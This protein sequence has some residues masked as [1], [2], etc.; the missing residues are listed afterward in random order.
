M[1]VSPVWLVRVSTYHSNIRVAKRSLKRQL[2][3]LKTL[4]M[5]IPGLGLFRKGRRAPKDSSFEAVAPDQD[6][7]VQ[8]AHEERRSLSQAAGV[9]DSV[10]SLHNMD[11][12]SPPQIAKKSPPAPPSPTSILPNVDFLDLSGSDGKGSEP[13]TVSP[14]EQHSLTQD[15]SEW[16]WHEPASEVDPKD[17]ATPDK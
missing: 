9:N 1:W 15:D 4:I 5:G 6:G 16:V 11:T 13:S 10:H 8:V 12:Q 17:A 2:S 7:V 3:G 14:D